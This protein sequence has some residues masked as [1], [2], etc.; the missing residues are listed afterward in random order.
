MQ[1]YAY[2]YP[3]TRSLIDDIAITFQE[4]SEILPDTDNES[5]LKTWQTV[6]EQAHLHATLLLVDRM[7][8]LMGKVGVC[9]RWHEKGKYVLL[10]VLT[11]DRTII[12]QDPQDHTKA[13]TVRYLIS[14]KSNTPQDGE[15][16]TWAEW[17]ADT[18]REVVIDSNFNVKKTLKEEANP[19]GRIPVSWFT[20]A[21]ELDEFWHDSGYPI[22]DTNEAVNIRLSNLM[23]AM[24]YQTVSLLVTTGLPESQ[25]VPVGVTQRLNIPPGIT[26]E[27]SGFGAE[28]ITPSPLLRDVWDLINQLILNVAKLYGL[29]AQSYNRD[30]SSFASGYQLKLSKQDIVNRNKMKKTMYREPIKYLCQLMADCYSINSKLFTFGTLDF[31][32][33]FADVQ[34][35]TNPIEQA[36]LNAIELGNGITSEVQILMDRNPDL[37]EEDAIELF[38][39]YKAHRQTLGIVNTQAIAE[40]MG[41]SE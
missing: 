10:D 26:G 29:S 4:T 38:K 7:V 35:E 25:S 41:V 11:P 40:S 6:L 37:T 21:L 32:I 34:F 23:L 24:D 1:K 14:E 9:V 30:S 17:T 39:K 31:T 33:D 12:E 19:Y 18:Y 20:N 3:L 13:I 8:E 36:Q 2:C 27:A 5:I 16:C 28:Y 22:I 15:V